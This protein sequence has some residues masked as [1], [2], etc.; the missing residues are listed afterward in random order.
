MNNLVLYPTLLQRN[1]GYVEFLTSVVNISTSSADTISVQPYA[2]KIGDLVDITQFCYQQ[3][4]QQHMG[5]LL[6]C[7]SKKKTTDGQKKIWM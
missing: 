3:V 2:L 7:Q 5:L 1:K 4:I 6:N